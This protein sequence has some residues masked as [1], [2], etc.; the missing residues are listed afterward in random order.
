MEVQ[1]LRLNEMTGVNLVIDVENYGLMVPPML[2]VTF[3]ENCFKHGVSPIQ[4]SVINI[5]LSER[6]GKLSFT[7]SNKIYPVKRIGEHMGIGNCRK[8]LELL[9]AGNYE[10]IINADRD[11]FNVSLNIGLES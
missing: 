2:L 3:V 6:D 10:L 5:T 11:I 4:K 8:R 7:T 1:A 9:Y